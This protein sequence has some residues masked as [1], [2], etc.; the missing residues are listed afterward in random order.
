[1]RGGE[2]KSRKSRQDTKR[3]EANQYM[4]ARKDR[5]TRMRLTGA[6]V[7]EIARK[8]GVTPSVLAL[9]MRQWMSDPEY[10]FVFMNGPNPYGETDEN[11]DTGT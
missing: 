5:V 10:S 11:L 2:T 3:I 7:A 8:L 6:S 4:E 9:E 1:M